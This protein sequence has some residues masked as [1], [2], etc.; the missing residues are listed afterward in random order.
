[1]DRLRYVRLSNRQRWAV[2]LTLIGIVLLALLILLLAHLRP[3]LTSMA[4][5]RVSNSVN[6][7]VAAAVEEAI[8]RGDINYEAF[9]TFE[10]DAT[11][12]VTALRS[13]VAEVNRMQSAIS[14]EILHRLSEVSTSELRIPIG[15]LTGSALL[16]GRGPYI[17]VRMQ[18][19]GSASAVFRN[20]FSAAGINQTRHQILLEVDVYMS[21]LL[22]GI[23]TST[24]VANEIAVAETVIVG[25]V[26]ESY[27]YFSASAEN[28]LDYA[29]DLIN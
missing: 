23:R 15:T 22:P 20:E 10:K 6:R 14:E 3:V 29:E 4:S 24:T 25:S 18:A 17:T 19:V 21:I 16:S 7:I 27:T 11:G 28:A 9:V 12:R 1:M 13:N 8:Q 5:A 26:P 2:W